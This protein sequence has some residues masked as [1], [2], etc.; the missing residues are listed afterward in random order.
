MASG[1]GPAA[2][3]GI[4][5]RGEFRIEGP[6]RDFDGST[7]AWVKVALLVILL[8]FIATGGYY[9]IRLVCAPA[10]VVD[11]VADP[12]RVIASYEWFYERYNRVQSI[13]RQISSALQALRGL[14]ADATAR[15]RDRLR[16]NLNGLCQL[17]A[18][19]VGDYNARAQMGMTRD[20]F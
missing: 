5:M 18:E 15:E 8:G 3:R 17:R 4:V 11:R 12:D 19:L 6:I 16:A 9:G 14:P 13:D 10:A 1:R 7:W 20:L 2:A